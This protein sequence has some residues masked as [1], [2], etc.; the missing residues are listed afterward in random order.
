MYCVNSK[1]IFHID[2]S[3]EF[4]PYFE[5]CITLCCFRVKRNVGNLMD[6]GRKLPVK[7]KFFCGYFIYIIHLNLLLK[8][9]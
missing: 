7:F 2:F 1:V 5:L 6:N 8:S 3:L 9:N 4:Y